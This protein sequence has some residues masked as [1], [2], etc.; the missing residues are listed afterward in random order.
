MLA[1]AGY[2]V[3]GQNL[4]TQGQQA[5][6]RRSVSAIW[7]YNAHAFADNMTIVAAI[8]G[9]DFPEDCKVGAFVNGECRGKGEYVDGRYFITVHGTAGESVSFVLYDEQTQTYWTVLGSLSFSDKAGS[10]KTPLRLKT[11]DQTTQIVI[12]QAEFK[13]ETPVFDL[14]GRRV[15]EPVKGMYFINGEK[16]IK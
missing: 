15:V 5:N 9:V 13:Q 11:G 12:S 7:D 10:V 2:N 6:G 8:D 4:S 3:L 1:W 14:L 16:I